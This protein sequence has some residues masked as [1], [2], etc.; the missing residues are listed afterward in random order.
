MLA[1]E[2]AVDE[3]AE[4]GLAGVAAPPCIPCT[5]ALALSLASLELSAPLAAGSG[6]AVCSLGAGAGWLTQDTNNNKIA[7]IKNNKRFMLVLS[8]VTIKI[9]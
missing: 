6:A 9:L 2:A 1:D 5:R 8:M 3:P 4:D 7:T